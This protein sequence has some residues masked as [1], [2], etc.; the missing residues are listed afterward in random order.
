MSTAAV[1]QT[2]PNEALVRQFDPVREYFSKVGGEEQFMREAS[3]AA[4]ILADLGARVI[5]VDRPAQQQ[6]DGDQDRWV[7]GGLG[8]RAPERRG[9]PSP[10]TRRPKWMSASTATT[11]R[12]ST[13]C[14]RSKES[15]TS[16][17]CVTLPSRKA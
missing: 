9:H 7:R 2:Q 6:T 17:I 5:R 4:Q 12:S 1:Q 15:M 10:G 13:C 11:S 16:R 8:E 14:T 3:F